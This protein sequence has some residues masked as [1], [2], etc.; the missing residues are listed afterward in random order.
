MRPAATGPPGPRPCSRCRPTAAAAPPA[1]PVTAAT[2][3]D[4][5]RALLNGQPGDPAL[6][7]FFGGQTRRLL[8]RAGQIDPG[9][10]DEARAA[11]AYVGLKTAAGLT[12]EEIVDV[13]EASGAARA[14]AGRTSPCI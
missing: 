6:R 9:C 8:A 4:A 11:G 10:L 1:L 3:V 7:E 14:A 13:V 12:P 2:A 5:A